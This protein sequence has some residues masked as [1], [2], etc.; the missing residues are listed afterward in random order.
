MTYYMKTLLAVLA[1]DLCSAAL[2]ASAQTSTSDDTAQRPEPE[3]AGAPKPKPKAQAAQ[4]EEPKANSATDH[5]SHDHTGHDHSA[6]QAPRRAID[7]NL[8]H[9]FTE[10]PDDHVIGAATAPITIIA[11]ASVTCPHC[12]QWFTSEW[13]KFKTE[14]IDTGQVRFVMR[15]YPTSPQMIARAGFSI[16]NCAPEEEYFKHLLTQ[17]TSQDMVFQAL[18]ENRAQEVYEGFA[19]RAGLATQE[20][21]YECLNDKQNQAGIDRSIMRADAAKITGV[22]SFFLNGEPIKGDLSSKALSARINAA[23]SGGI[24]LPEPLKTAPEGVSPYESRP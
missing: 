6:H 14:H 10:A 17:M 21:M 11:Y 3:M 2:N 8:D 18:R 1:F 23:A 4:T 5:G 7:P 16:I 9:V 13:P 12:G 20:A 15:E 24:S 19:K 22:P